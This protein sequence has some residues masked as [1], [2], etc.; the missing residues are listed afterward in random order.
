VQTIK[1]LQ[2]KQMNRTK[3]ILL[4][5]LYCLATAWLAA[6]EA[7]PWSD[8]LVSNMQQQYQKAQGLFDKQTAKWLTKLQKQEEKLK[9]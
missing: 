1:D 5:L 6:Q 9:K 4:T 3:P 8:K 7:K 2:T